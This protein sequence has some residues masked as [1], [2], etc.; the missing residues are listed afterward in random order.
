MATPVYTNGGVPYQA[1]PA[2]PQSGAAQ[3]Y[4]GQPQYPAPGYQGQTQAGIQQPT[5]LHRFNTGDEFKDN[6]GII[7]LFVA[8]GLMIAACT[9]GNHQNSRWFMRLVLG[10]M[11]ILIFWIVLG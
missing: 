9:L 1:A 3:V 5:G 2:I 7:A 8:V 4:P 11:S 10:A 6:A